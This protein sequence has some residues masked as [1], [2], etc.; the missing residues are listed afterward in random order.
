VR[1]VYNKCI[2]CLWCRVCDDWLSCKLHYSLWPNVS[3]SRILFVRLV[4]VFGQ[5]G[6]L[7]I[8]SK[9]YYFG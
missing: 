2:T 1:D 4:T 7:E 5:W 3:S 6:R 9:T 8:L